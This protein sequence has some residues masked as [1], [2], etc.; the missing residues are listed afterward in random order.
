MYDLVVEQMVFQDTTG[1]SLVAQKEFLVVEI[2]V[3]GR[4]IHMW[5]Q[6]LHM[7]N[8]KKKNGLVKQT[9]VVWV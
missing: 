8:R 6:A 5:S 4:C 3:P 2:F 7:S 9:L 1:N